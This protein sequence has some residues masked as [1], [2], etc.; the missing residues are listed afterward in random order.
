MLAV[1]ECCT[2]E[3][4]RG[5]FHAQV[6]IGGRKQIMNGRKEERKAMQ[7]REETDPRRRREQRD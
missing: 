4:G 7:N 3:E 5:E 1:G 2:T 6:V